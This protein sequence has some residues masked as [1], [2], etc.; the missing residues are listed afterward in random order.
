MENGSNGENACRT[1]CAAVIF[2]GL[3]VYCDFFQNVFVYI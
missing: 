1:F 2:F 3:K